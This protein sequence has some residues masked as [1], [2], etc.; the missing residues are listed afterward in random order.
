MAYYTRAL[1]P[2]IIPES[3]VFARTLRLYITH[4][5]F[6]SWVYEC[7]DTRTKTLHNRESS[8]CNLSAISNARTR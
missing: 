8:V 2:Y 3:I 4:S 6:I 1:R 7:E 5:D